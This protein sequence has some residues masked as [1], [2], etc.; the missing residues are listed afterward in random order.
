[1][2]DD[3]LVPTDGSAAVESAVTHAVELA[4]THDA[5]VHALYAV[6]PLYTPDP[7]FDRVYTAMEAEGETA[8]E[9]VAE[10]ARGAGLVAET[11][12][13]RGEPHQ[14]IVEYAADYEVDP[15]AMG[16]HGRTGLDRYLVGS[17]TEKVVRT[18][19]MPVLTVRHLPDRDGDR[20]AGD[21]EP[22]AVDRR[23]TR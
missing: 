6:Q 19:E 8:V 15:I 9:T 5:T 1:M 16:T 20:A 21:T 18:A 22:G 13:R 4:E 23:P 7:G 17:V 14:Q 2:Y 11:A 10:R 12:V 3:V